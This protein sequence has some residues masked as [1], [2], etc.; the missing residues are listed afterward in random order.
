[1]PTFISPQMISPSLIGAA[2]GALSGPPDR[3]AAYPVY[4]LT[5]RFAVTVDDISDLGTWATCQGLR[6]EFKTK[7]IT[8]GGDYTSSVTLPDRM[9]YDRITLERAMSRQ[10]SAGV[11]R[12]LVRMKDEWMTPS[13]TAAKRSRNDGCNAR[14]RLLDPTDPARDIATWDLTNVFPVSWT[15]PSFT[16]KGSE[17]ALETLVL[18]HGGFL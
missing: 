1:M 10:D 16:A 7:Q 12:W 5:M 11:R 13:A 17:V 14:I 15:G 3:A 18:Q 8:Q 6:V 2:A 4:G 9:E